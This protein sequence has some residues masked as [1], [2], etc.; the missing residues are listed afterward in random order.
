M[1][2]LYS[3]LFLFFG[4]GMLITCAKAPDSEKP[5]ITVQ[6]P[7]AN[8]TAIMGTDSFHY[9]VDISDN[10][11]IKHVEIF[12]NSF[13]GIPGTV[14]M[15]KFSEY[16][17]E[18]NPGTTN[19]VYQDSFLPKGLGYDPAMYQMTVIVQDNQNETRKDVNFAM[20]K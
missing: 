10:E 16:Y 4:L 18:Y 5:K 1:S 6:F 15:R 8:D 11:N 3:C 20:G 19:S 13:G 9:K 17:R 12:L 7:Q 2:K 14:E